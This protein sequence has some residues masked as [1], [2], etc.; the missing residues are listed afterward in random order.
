[1][2][3]FSPGHHSCFHCLNM[4]LGLGPAKWPPRPLKGRPLTTQR[5][6][7]HLADSL[8]ESPY[9]CLVQRRF[10]S[11]EPHRSSVVHSIV[12]WTLV[13]CTFPWDGGTHYEKWGEWDQ[14]LRA[15]WD[16][17]VFLQ[18]PML[19]GSGP[20]WSFQVMLQYKQ[21]QWRMGKDK[22]EKSRLILIRLPS[23]FHRAVQ[24]E[25][26]VHWHVLCSRWDDCFILA[27]DLAC[28]D[29]WECIAQIILH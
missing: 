8:L 27:I 7:M 12:A 3:R 16:C 23:A 18:N 21:S 1:M 24:C 14:F 2:S 19:Q 20:E 6:K 5:M 9:F 10:E 26:K 15:R 11:H 13:I 17:H 4:L 22:G 29:P 25:V 28:I